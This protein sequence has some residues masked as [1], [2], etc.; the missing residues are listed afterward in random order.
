MIKNEHQALLYGLGAVALWSTVATAFKFSLE[1]LSPTGLLAIAASTS[2]VVFA[3]L[4]TLRRR[5]SELA[6]LK[7]GQIRLGLAIGVLNPALYYFLLFAAYDRLPAQEAMALNYTWAL[8]LPLL[9]APLLKHRLTGRE[10]AAA[11]VSYCGVYVIATRGNLLDVAFASPTG[12]ILALASTLVWALC[13]ILNTHLKVEP[14]LGLFLNFSAATPLI[15][16]IATASGS[17]NIH[18]AEGLLGGVYVGVFEMGISFILWLTAMQ[19]TQRTVNISTLIFLSPPISLCLIWLVLGE[20]I[21]RSTLAGLALILAGLALQ[22][23][24]NKV[25]ESVRD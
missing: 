9:A 6:A 23:S 2:W 22:H 19:L 24:N 12:V 10:L 18:A 17:L 25:S 15:L 8:T 7:S 5:W 13:W 11:A 1:Y 16:I 21:M 14:I 20:P 3:L 4:I